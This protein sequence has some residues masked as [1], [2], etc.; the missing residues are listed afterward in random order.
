VVFIAD[1]E[2][3]V[4]ALSASNGHLIWETKVG[5]TCDISSPTLSGGLVFIGTRDFSDG[6]FYAL[7]ENTGVILWRYPI[8]AS[9][10]C[11]PSVVD[12]MMLCG[13]DGWNMYAF[14]VGV[15]GGDWLLHRYDAWNTAYSPLG[16]SRWESVQAACSSQG[17]IITCV[18]TNRYDHL[19]RNIT[20]RLPFPG[21]WYT[22]TGEVLKENAESYTLNSLAST[23]S[24]TLLITQEPLFQVTITKP[25]NGIYLANTKILPFFFPL[26]FG[27][28]DV[29]A[30]VRTMN[31]TGVDR[32]E[33][34]L[35][36]E[37]QVV[38]TTSPYSWRW[39]KRSFG[40]HR[41]NVIAYQNNVSVNDELTVCKIL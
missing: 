10:T 6:A 11:P 20:L 27:K 29:E 13:S 8:G 2:G 9:V 32:V 39:S 40:F 24:R 26:V 17:S 28:I 14:D 30:T 7:N 31:E 23:E 4:Y 41:V 33:F 18:V 1:T 22:E 34:Y 12:G 38:D 35:D 36:N 37:L 5:G 21:Y 19:V 16:L 25:E 15:G 3:Y